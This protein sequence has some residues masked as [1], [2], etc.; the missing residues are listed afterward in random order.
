VTWFDGFEGK[1]VLVTGASSGIGRATA[2]A[3]GRS[4]ARVALVARRQQALQAVADEIIEKGGEALVAPADVTQPAAVRDCVRTTCDRF[5]RID[6]VVNNA[7]MLIPSRVIDLEPRDLRAM[8]DVNVFGALAVMQEAARVMQ[9]QDDGCIVNV[10]SLAG[11]RGVTPLGGYCAS[12]FALVGL[13]EALRTELHG[14][15]VHVGLVL[16]GIVDTP[17]V[18][19]AEGDEPFGGIWPSV[20]NMPPSWVVWAVFA[21]V[22]FRLVEISVPPGAATLEKL[23]SLAP[24][25]ADSVIHWGTQATQWLSRLLGGART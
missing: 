11:R 12:K 9:R 3:F 1:S 14:S 20:F 13:T 22:R 7:G 17:M 8:F 5:E 10:A 19:G 24:G 23:A 4:G 16:P 15:R 18:H 25:I 6:V 2:L 21:A